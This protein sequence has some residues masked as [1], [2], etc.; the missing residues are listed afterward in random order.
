MLASWA[1]DAPLIFG[2][3][4]N[5]RPRDSRV[6]EQLEQCFGLVGATSPDSLDHLLV[7]GLERI[8]PATAWPAARREIARDGLAIRL[9]DH[10]PVEACFTVG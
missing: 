10:A 5:V 9:S 1:D 2:G 6:F 3:D 8:E 4:L 7:R